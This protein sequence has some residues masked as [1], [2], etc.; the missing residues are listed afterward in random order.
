ML[1]ASGWHA[2]APEFDLEF[3]AGEPRMASS[4]AKAGFGR[5]DDLV[6]LHF[7]WTRSGPCAQR[8]PVIVYSVRCTNDGSTTTGNVQVA[9]LPDVSVAV[10]VTIVVPRGKKLPEGGTQTMEGLGS[11]S[12][13]AV[14]EKNTISPG[15]LRL[16]SILV[17]MGGQY[18]TGGVESEDGTRK[19]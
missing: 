6:R 5:A 7:G 9:W 3:E 2:C 17:T 18:R 15:G 1:V 11:W 4:R 14:T 10:Q 13:I 16:A 12:S 8:V 19:T